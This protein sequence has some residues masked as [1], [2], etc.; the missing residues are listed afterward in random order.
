VNTPGLEY[1]LVYIASFVF[2][3]GL[4]GCVGFLICLLID[5]RRSLHND[6]KTDDR[7]GDGST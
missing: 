2:F 3:M 5:F 4:V 6:Q 1:L 7:H